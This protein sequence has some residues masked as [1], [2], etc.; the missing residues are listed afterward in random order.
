LLAWSMMSTI[1]FRCGSAPVLDIAPRGLPALAR[2][3]RG[4]PG[5]RPPTPI[6]HITGDRERRRDARLHM[7]QARSTTT[8]RKPPYLQGRGEGD[9]HQ[10]GAAAGD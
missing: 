3:A 10:V 8:T 9:G 7:A 2:L 4:V 5:G 6:P 1:H